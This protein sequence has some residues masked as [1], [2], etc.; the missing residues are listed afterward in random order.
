MSFNSQTEK[1]LWSIFRIWLLCKERILPFF[2]YS[3][4]ELLGISIYSSFNFLYSAMTYAGQLA[5]LSMSCHLSLSCHLLTKQIGLCV[6]SHNS[7]TTSHSLLFSLLHPPPM[8]DPFM[9]LQV[10][11]LTWNM[12]IC[13]L[14][15]QM[16]RSHTHISLD[17]D[18]GFIIQELHSELH[19]VHAEQK[20]IQHCCDSLISST[21]VVLLIS[22]KAHRK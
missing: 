8:Y 7:Y 22:V 4:K 10:C 19:W 2:G 9:W 20:A 5:G 12:F 16:S 17:S 13:L 6:S 15:S 11:P 18:S 3:H 14:S 21:F 1:R